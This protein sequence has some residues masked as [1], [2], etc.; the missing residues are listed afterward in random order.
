MSNPGTDRLNH[1]TAWIHLCAGLFVFAGGFLTFLNQQPQFMG[2]LK[3]QSKQITPKQNPKVSAAETY[4]LIGKTLDH[5]DNQG[6]IAAYTKAIELKPDHA[7]AY[8][9]RAILRSISGDVKGAIEDYNQAISLNPD[10]ASIVSN[11]GLTRSAL[12]DRK[13]AVE[14]YNQAV[15]LNLDSA[16]AYRNWGVF[17]SEL[18]GDKKAA[19]D[20]FNKA[21]ELYKKERNI[22]RSQDALDRA[23]KLSK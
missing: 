1:K 4:Y 18:V 21:A 9:N 10:A 11:R 2:M 7:F 13:G 17:W 23:N 3:S 14:D 22:N 15:K 20:D 12:G 19:I 16:V 8:N 6:A 5:K